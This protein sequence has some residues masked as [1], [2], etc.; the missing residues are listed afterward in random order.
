MTNDQPE[1]VNADGSTAI[2]NGSDGPTESALVGEA[3]EA[4]E[5]D[6]ANSTGVCVGQIVGIVFAAVGFRV[7]SSSLHDNSFFTH[8]ATGHLILDTGSIPT[9]DPYSF[10]ALG[11]PW[12][13]QSW[14]ASVIYA[15]LDQT[16][17]LVGIRLMVGILSGL[18]AYL[19]WKLTEPADGLVGRL[20][21][22]VPVLGIGA[23]AWVERPLIFSLVALLAVIFAVENRL[24]PRWM[25][26]LMW[27]WVN[28]HGSFPLG[29][30]AIVAY[31]FGRFLD[32]DRPTVELKV[33]GWAALGTI[34]G[35]IASPVGLKLLTFPFQLLERREAF[36]AVVEWQPP[37]WQEP[38]ELFFALQAVI[39]VGLVLLRSRKWRNFVPLV[40]FVGI[41]LQS[42]RNIVHASLVIIPAMV[43]GAGGLGSVSSLRKS[44][45]LV[46]VR[47]I[48]GVFALV[49]VGV[50]VR[51]PNTNLVDYPVKA[52]KWMQQNDLL[53]PDSR[54]VTRD[55][56]GNYFEMRFGPDE[57]RTYID[58]R[59]DMYPIELIRNY[60]EL[61]S[62]DG[63]F[64]RVLSE[65]RATAVLWDTDSYLSSWLEDPDN[66]W[67]VVYENK[68]WVVA[69]PAKSK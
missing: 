13:V 53:G 35:G 10:T 28:V 11:H 24:D 64:S 44:P 39:A 68:K 41:S 33:L 5:D 54:V 19:V 50:G 51:Q 23:G 67:V 57:V 29:L 16:F 2:S 26:P 27:L 18:C 12:T 7:G 60:S 61:T 36:S 37:T 22:A 56:V 69:V 15:L 55:F 30:A 42:T 63:D 40:L 6:T 45:K 48:V 38:V 59:V 65:A 62:E 31:G 14:G 4:N 21:I 1:V 25:V 9:S 17:G 20:A 43:A 32:R 66:G 46:P 8:L 3:A 34:L 58:D 47:M 52:A 49:L